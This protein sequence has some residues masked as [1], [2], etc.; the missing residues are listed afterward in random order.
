MA[1]GSGP[2]TFSS[3]LDIKLF[4]K[5]DYEQIWNL[6]KLFH[7]LIRRL[8]TFPIPTV[9]V[10]NGHCVAGGVL[11][12]LGFE[13]VIMNGNPKCKLK[14]N[15]VENGLVV[16]GGLIHLTAFKT[17]PHTLSMLLLA[18]KFSPQTA[19]SS[20]IIHSLYRDDS[21]LFD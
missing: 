14:L 9:C 11:L 16:P 8:L 15:E 21:D 20:G 10:V 13:H 19:L 12:S 2:K 7:H 6:F 3:G 17:R 18:K 1:I 4:K 5:K